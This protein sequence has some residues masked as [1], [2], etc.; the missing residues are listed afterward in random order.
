M[1]F[2]KKCRSYIKIKKKGFVRDFPSNINHE[3]VIGTLV[4]ECLAKSTPISHLY[5]HTSMSSINYVAELMSKAWI[6]YIVYASTS[7]RS[8]PWCISRRGDDD[9]VG[10]LGYEIR[11]YLAFTVFEAMVSTC[12]SCRSLFYNINWTFTA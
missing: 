2:K 3:L 6:L 7:Y 5:L 8:I 4:L 10:H 11:C 12:R 9:M 1:T